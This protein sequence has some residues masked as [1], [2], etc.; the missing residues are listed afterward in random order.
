MQNTTSYIKKYYNRSSKKK[1][2]G[3]RSNTRE[4]LLHRLEGSIGKVYCTTLEGVSVLGNNLPIRRQ[5]SC[6]T[7]K[8]RHEIFLDFHG[9]IQNEEQFFLGDNNGLEHNKKRKI[10][11]EREKL[12]GKATHSKVWRYRYDYF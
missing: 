8:S 4:I 9:W 6:N 2:G 7:P 3:K 10:K 1:K 12:Q 11:S 5:Y